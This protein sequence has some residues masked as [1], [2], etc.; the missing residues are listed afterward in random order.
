MKTA[1]YV[2][3]GVVQL[4]ITPVSE[5]EKN[6]LANFVEK[7]LQVKIFEGSFYDCRG[8]WVCQTDF[9]KESYHYP[10]LQKNKDKS[11]II[12]VKEKTKEPPEM[13]FNLCPVCGV[14]ICENSYHTL[15]PEESVLFELKVYSNVCDDCYKK[16]S[17]NNKPQQE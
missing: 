10:Y 4:V 6:A 8:G 16:L 12:T 3:D 13:Y 14:K 11:I 17:L 5:F 7:D 2:E 9:P 15:T 1:I